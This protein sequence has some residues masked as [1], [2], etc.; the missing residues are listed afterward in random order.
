MTNF[1]DDLP[2]DLQELIMKTK[3]NIEKK[4][5]R[6]VFDSFEVKVLS[7][8]VTRPYTFSL[9]VVYKDKLLVHYKPTDKFMIVTYK[10]KG[11]KNGK[12]PSD[13]IIANLISG[14]CDWK[15]ECDYAME[16]NI[17]MKWNNSLSYRTYCKMNNSTDDLTLREFCDWRREIHGLKK[18]LDVECDD[19]LRIYDIHGFQSSV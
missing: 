19:F 18:V 14:V 5:I 4:D 16:N 2:F 10:H 17:D 1:F 12:I 7:S 3:V 15:D 8:K 13:K 11:F 9:D 6:D